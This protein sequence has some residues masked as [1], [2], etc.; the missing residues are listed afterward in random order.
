MNRDATLLAGNRTKS[1]RPQIRDRRLYDDLYGHPRSVN[2]REVLRR[3]WLLR[4]TDR[5]VEH[6]RLR[7]A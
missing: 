2:T 3:A 4:A 5:I 7:L 1:P 6:A